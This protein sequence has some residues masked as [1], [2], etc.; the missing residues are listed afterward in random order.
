MSAE[1]L[2]L[3]TIVTKNPHII[4]AVC[5]DQVVNGS[6]ISKSPDQTYPPKTLSHRISP[7]F[8]TPSMRSWTPPSTTPPAAARRCGSSCQWRPIPASGGGVARRVRQVSLALTQWV[9]VQEEGGHF[10]VSLVLPAVSSARDVFV[11]TQKG[12]CFR[13]VRALFLAVSESLHLSY[14]MGFIFNDGG[15]D[16]AKRRPPPSAPSNTL[17]ET[18]RDVPS[19]FDNHS[20]FSFL[21]SSLFSPPLPP[22]FSELPGKYSYVQ[23]NFSY[24]WLGKQVVREKYLKKYIFLCVCVLLFRL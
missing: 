8:S 6:C 3:C 15:S 9:G 7:A 16:R 14:S 23:L 17:K 24:W 22:P 12:G 11:V 2:C 20:H 1:I 13:P 4:F 5:H 21:Q 19:P 10:G 18:L